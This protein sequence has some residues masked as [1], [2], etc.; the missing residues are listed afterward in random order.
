MIALATATLLTQINPVLG[1]DLFEGDARRDV[2]GVET[3]VQLGGIVRLEDDLS[4]G[5]GA[6][7]TPSK[8][9]RFGGHGLKPTTGV[10]SAQSQCMP[11]GRAHAIPRVFSRG[12][13]RYVV[14]AIRPLAGASDRDQPERPS[15]KAVRDALRV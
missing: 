4:R 11:S 5:A 3:A 6:A 9:S 15:S 8:G 14:I 2:E 1:R 10:L 13:V 12:C 7:V